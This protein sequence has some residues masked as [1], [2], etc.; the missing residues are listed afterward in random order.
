MSPAIRPMP[1]AVPVAMPGRAPGSSTRRIVAALRLAE[2]VGRLA[3]WRGIACSASRVAPTISGSAIS[4]I[5]AP[6]A[7]NE[8][9]KTAPPSAVNDRKPKSSLREHD[10]AEDREHDARRA[11][12][13]LD[14]RL[15][16]A[17]QPERAAVLGQPDRDRDAERRG[18]RRA[19]DRQQ[20]RADQRVEEAAGLALVEVRQ[21]AAEEQ[22][23]VAGTGPRERACRR[24]SRR[25]SAQSR[26]PAAQQSPRPIRS[27]SGQRGARLRGARAPQGSGARLRRGFHQIPAP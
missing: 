12:D 15:D 25:R 8:R 5:I 21:R 6:A 19:E 24:R 13:D 17:R 9:P 1:S 23:R 18:D 20:E 3:T 27:I 26:M 11:G 2:R 10:Q 14:A 22:A 16:R 7:K 4:D